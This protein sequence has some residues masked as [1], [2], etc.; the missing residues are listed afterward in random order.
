[1][2]V[3]LASRGDASARA[4]C[5]R[6]PLGAARVLAWRDLSTPDWRHYSDPD[7][8]E[9]TTVVAGA[10]VLD[11]A[12]SAVVTR[13]S[14]VPPHELSHILPSDRA[15]VAAEMTASLAAWLAG[16][17]CPVINPATANSLSGPRW[18]PERWTMLAASLGL[19]ALPVVRRAVPGLMPSRPRAS[20]PVGFEQASVTVVGPRVIHHPRRDGTAQPQPDTQLDGQL[21][22]DSRALATVAQLTLL[23]VHWALRGAEHWFLGAD[24]DVDLAAAPVAEALLE[25]VGLGTREP[26]GAVP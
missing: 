16:L 25:H 24:L 3:V 9:D 4:L 1:V 13:C 20:A 18:Q 22:D 12:I 10:R 11:T 8:G 19:R 6:A 15:Y 5:E 17:R 23:R 7:D 21:A 14:W 2:L 26:V